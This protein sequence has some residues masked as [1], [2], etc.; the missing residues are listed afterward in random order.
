MSQD[1]NQIEVSDI[2]KDIIQDII[3]DLDKG[4]EQEPKPR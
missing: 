4:Q 1:Q 2:I 3:Q